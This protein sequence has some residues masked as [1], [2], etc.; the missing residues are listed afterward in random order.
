MWNRPTQEELA[1]LPA[2]YSTEN[3]PLKD[4]MIQMHFFI[5]GCD[6]WAVEYDPES[7]T[8]FGFVI[9]NND[10]EM[11]EWGYFS[12]E[13]LDQIRIKFIQIDRDLYFS[14][15][16]AIEVDQIRKSPMME[17]RVSL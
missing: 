9:F 17:E 5:C 11:A 1:Q 7:Q 10:L 4:K 15:R 13:E 16:K 2:F 6:W 8:F 14:P 3:V 12:L